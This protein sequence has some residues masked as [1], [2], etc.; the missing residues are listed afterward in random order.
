MDPRA[1]LHAVQMLSTLGGSTY[2]LLLLVPNQGGNKTYSWVVVCFIYI[3]KEYLIFW[4]NFREI[5]AKSALTDNSLPS[6]GTITNTLDKHQPHGFSLC[7][8]SIKL[9][10]DQKAFHVLSFTQML[11]P[12][13]IPSGFFSLFRHPCHSSRSWHAQKGFLIF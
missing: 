13:V 11:F 10:F 2:F 9:T 12:W 5:D 8:S 3:L 1:K 4:L 6:P 7:F